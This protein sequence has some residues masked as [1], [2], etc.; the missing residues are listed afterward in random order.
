VPRGA[1]LRP[2]GPTDGYRGNCPQEGD[3][4]ALHLDVE[5]DKHGARVL[6]EKAGVED[7]YRRPMN[8]L[9]DIPEPGSE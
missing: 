6:S 1:R 8:K 7:R 3:F 5:S 9:L 4:K 2:P